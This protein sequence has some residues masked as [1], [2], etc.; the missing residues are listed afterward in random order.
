VSLAPVA[1]GEKNLKSEKCN[2]GTKTV[3]QPKK[4]H[5]IRI[6]CGD[7]V[8]F[9][10]GG[11]QVVAVHKGRGQKVGSL[12]VVVPKGGGQMVADLRG[13]LV[14]GPRTRGKVRPESRAELH[15]DQ[16]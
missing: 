8:V 3:G 2:A 6:A 14:A 13:Q 12:M 15:E 4:V 7:A 9:P 16:A 11:G 5:L 10:K 1:N